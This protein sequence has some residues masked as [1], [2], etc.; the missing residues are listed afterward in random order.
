MTENAPDLTT[1]RPSAPETE[2]P[3]AASLEG[4]ADPAAEPMEQAPAAPAGPRYK[5]INSE[6]RCECPECLDD[7]VELDFFSAE[8]QHKTKGTVMLYC[9]RTGRKYFTPVDAFQAW[10]AGVAPKP[11]RKRGG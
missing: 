10:F 4:A 11:G 9:Q 1:D 6:L 7:P 8:E 5:G 3:E 2:A